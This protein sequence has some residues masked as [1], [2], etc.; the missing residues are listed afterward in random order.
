MRR[1][2]KQLGLVISAPFLMVL[3]Y[4]IAALI[5]GI[6]P[7]GFQKPLQ[8]HSTQKKY[9]IYLLS[10]ALHAD[11][12]I[13]LTPQTLK[14]FAFLGKTDF[15]LE[16]PNLEYLV[17]G[18]G[19]REFYTSTADYSDMELGTI[20]RAAT[21]DR[22]V[23][24]VAPA[25]DISKSEGSVELQLSEEG[26][27][28]LLDFIL[29]S[30]VKTNNNPILLPDA[31]FGYGDVFYEAKGRFNIFNPCNVWVSRALTKAGMTSGVW[32]PTTYSLL[33]NSKLYH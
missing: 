2:L 8:N 15:P 12:A 3:L 1:T 9:S 31:T 4:L 27:A 30:F 22:A 6:V 18:W 29:E 25:G 23:M 24:H 7:G 17:M 28:R 32:T 11:M 20:W 5:G 33:L 21:G 26:F 13:P 19:S 16:N 10:N 14:H